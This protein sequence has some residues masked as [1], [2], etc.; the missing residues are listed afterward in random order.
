M[1]VTEII[2]D[3]KKRGI[4]IE[5]TEGKIRLHGREDTLGQ[6][7]VDSVKARKA[8]LISSLTGANTQKITFPMNA[9]ALSEFK[10]LSET[11]IRFNFPQENPDPLHA[12]KLCLQPPTAMSTRQ[13]VFPAA[14]KPFGAEKTNA[15]SP[16]ICTKCHPPIPGRDEIEFLQEGRQQEV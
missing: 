13:L 1:I 3:L 15:S 7:T 14:I 6:S 16:W 4:T 2:A 5:A 12:R 11:G 8:E 9:G 10:R